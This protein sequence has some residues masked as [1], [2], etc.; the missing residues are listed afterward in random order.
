MFLRHGQAVCHFRYLHAFKKYICNLF[1]VALYLCMLSSFTFLYVTISFFFRIFLRFTIIELLKRLL[2]S[3]CF[4]LHCDF[5]GMLSLSLSHTHTH[6]HARTH[7]RTHTHTHTLV[8][9]VLY[10]TF[11]YF[12]VNTKPVLTN[13]HWNKKI[14]VHPSPISLIMKVCVRGSIWI[15]S[16][17][18]RTHSS[19]I[20]FP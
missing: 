18:W 14:E 10:K 5:W 9:F 11:I 4:N 2:Y 16:S 19:L 6:T 7:A 8:N 12:L 1:C 17:R 20:K 15:G 3:H 13:I